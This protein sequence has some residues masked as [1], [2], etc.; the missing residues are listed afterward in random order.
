MTRISCKR[1]D[2]VWCD[3]DE[4]V[5]LEIAVEIGEGGCLTYEA[6]LDSPEYQEP[7]WVAIKSGKKTGKSTVYRVQKRG[8]KI[9]CRGRVFYT[10]E[11]TDERGSFVVTDAITG[12]EVGSFAYLKKRWD[13]F[14]ALVEVYPDVMSYPAAELVGGKCVPIG[15][16]EIQDETPMITPAEFSGI[17]DELKN[18]Y[19]G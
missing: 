14:L 3:P 15:E 1:R 18:M 19:G 13:A 6:I 8:K 17:L 4:G 16:D 11:K 5:C 7:F 9:E 2:C 12:C 10:T